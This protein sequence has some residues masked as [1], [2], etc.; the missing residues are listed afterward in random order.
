MSAR[1]AI[2]A[3]RRALLAGGAAPAP[4]TAK[5]DRCP[6]CGAHTQ[7]RLRGRLRQLTTDLLRA[8][9]AERAAPRIEPE[10]DDG[11]ERR[12]RYRYW[13]R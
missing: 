6:T 8:E 11:E 4:I 7:H 9:I 2:L 5:G 12:D 3:E 10:A 1:A 13:D